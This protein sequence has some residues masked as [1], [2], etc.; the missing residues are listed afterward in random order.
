MP[1]LGYEFKQHREMVPLLQKKGGQHVEA[2]SLQSEQSQLVEIV[3][4]PQDETKPQPITVPSLDKEYRQE[5]SMH[6]EE[7]EPSAVLS[8]PP[9]RSAMK[10]PTS[11]NHDITQTHSYQ[12]YATPVRVYVKRTTER[13][14]PFHYAVRSLPHP[15]EQTNDALYLRPGLLRYPKPLNQQDFYARRDTPKSTLLQ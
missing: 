9:L 5:T 10:P 3:P 15:E 7:G 12:G 11:F 6:L 1:S 13:N 4:S 14:Q 8:R 2:Q